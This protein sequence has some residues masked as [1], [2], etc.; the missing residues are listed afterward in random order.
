[1]VSLPRH[2]RNYNVKQ[3]P[4][5]RIQLENRIKL[6]PDQERTILYMLEKIVWNSWFDHSASFTDTLMS[7]NKL[8]A[9]QHPFIDE[10]I[11]WY[12]DL[13]SLLVALRM[14]NAKQPVPENTRDCWFTRWSMLLTV[15]WNEPDFGLKNVYPWILDV[16]TR[17]VNNE[18]D[19]L[20]ETL[21]KQL[22]KHLDSVE[23]R[24]YFDFEAVIIYLLRWD[25][26]NYWSQFD[27][28]AAIKRFNDMTSVALK[29]GRIEPLLSELDRSVS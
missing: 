12:F 21:L 6:L 1:M 16:N 4:I 11:Y 7:A 8:L 5:S 24:H 20:E 9:G 22:W 14:R 19:I 26:V 2:S 10:I 29:T 18:S 15:N 25:I 27:E 23:K 17:L 3:T 28:A 13:R